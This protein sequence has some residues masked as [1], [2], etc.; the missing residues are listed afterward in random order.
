MTGTARLRVLLADD[1]ALVR[2]G[3]RRVLELAERFELVGETERESFRQLE[4][5][6]RAHV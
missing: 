3:V 5:I 2:A 1:H 6:G 4:Q